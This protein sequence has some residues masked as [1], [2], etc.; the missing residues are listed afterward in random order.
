MDLIKD[1][2]LKNVNIIPEIIKSA[3][4]DS[5]TQTC[6]YFI[7]DLLHMVQR[8]EYIDDPNNEQ[9]FQDVLQVI[10]S[11]PQDFVHISSFQS[12]LK[13]QVLEILVRKQWT[14]ILEESPHLYVNLN[15]I[16]EKLHI[17]TKFEGHAL[18]Q[19]SRNRDEK[20]SVASQLKVRLI[21]NISSLVKIATMS[22]RLSENEEIRSYLTGICIDLSYFQ[23]NQGLFEEWQEYEHHL[24][25]WFIKQCCMLKNMEWVQMFFSQ[26][27]H[28]HSMKTLVKNINISKLS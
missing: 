4:P 5:E 17:T 8:M 16:H 24:H 15:R 10:F 19:P 6:L 18:R 11:R 20:I 9:T 23:S 13:L 1:G 7:H 22:E 21:R 26:S 25:K 14:H 27:N 3:T 12:L 28:G 2:F